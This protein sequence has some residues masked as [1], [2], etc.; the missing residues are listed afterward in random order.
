MK[1][2]IPKFDEK[3]KFAGYKT[4]SVK[5]HMDFEDEQKILQELPGFPQGYC[6]S[7]GKITQTKTP[8]EL[9]RFYDIRQRGSTKLRGY[10]IA[11]AD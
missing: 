11:V 8:I 1:I 7:L 9:T 2:I 6:S 3:I 10:Y 4:V 5:K